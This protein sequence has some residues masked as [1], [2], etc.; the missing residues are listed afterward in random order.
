MSDTYFDINDFEYQQDLQ[1]GTQ[2]ELRELTP[3]EFSH[4]L[5]CG[6]LDRDIELN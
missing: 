3:E 6:S 4:F 1:Y 5:C 2:E